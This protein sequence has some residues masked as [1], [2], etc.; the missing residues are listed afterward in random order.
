M[1]G[2]MQ[3]GK[4]KK[5]KQNKGRKLKQKESRGVGKVRKQKL[6]KAIKDMTTEKGKRKKSGRTILIRKS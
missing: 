3:V 6:I 1:K 4:E 2:Q 5:T